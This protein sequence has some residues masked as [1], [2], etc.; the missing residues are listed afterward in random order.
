M[1]SENREGRNVGESAKYQLACPGLNDCV[2]LRECPQILVEAT[3]RCYNS[4]RSL[5]CGV[6]QNYEPYICCPTY[7]SP[8]YVAQAPTYVGQSPQ[9]P[10]YISE[11]ANQLGNP[12]KLNGQCGRSLIQGNFYKKLGAFPFAARVGFKSKEIFGKFVSNRIADGNLGHEAIC[13]LHFLCLQCVD[14]LTR[15]HLSDLIAVM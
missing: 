11:P 6:N 7:Q 3:K 2:P 12:D 8:S 4:D 5:F 13:Y 1:K 10:T 15:A 9:A 14:N